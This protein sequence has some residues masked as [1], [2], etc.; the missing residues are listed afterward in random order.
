MA[1][2][3]PRPLTSAHYAAGFDARVAGSFVPRLVR[4]RGLPFFTTYWTL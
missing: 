2:P 3:A 1:M 4:Y